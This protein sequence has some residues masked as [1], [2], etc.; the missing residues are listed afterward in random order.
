MERQIEARHEAP[1][2]VT[3][4][5]VKYGYL[6]FIGEFE[7]HGRE[8]LLPSHP[9]LVETD[10]GIELGQ[11]LCYSCDLERGLCVLPERIKEYLGASGPEYLKRRAGK[12]VRPANAQDLMEEQH[13]RA[14]AMAKKSFCMQAAQRYSLKLKIICVE[15]LFG[16]E[17]I[18]FY[19]TA[20]GRVD[21]RELVRELAREY[22]TR[23]ELRQIGARDEARLLADYE[24]CGRECCCKNFLKT[25]RPVNMKMAKLQKATLDPSKV[26]GRCGRLRCCLRYE[27]RTYEDLV[28]QL[29]GI[30]SFVQTPN[31]IG[32][33]KDR[34]VLTQL[35]QVVLEDN[36]LV[37]FP[38]EELSP[39]PPRDGREARD[40][41]D[42]RDSRDR[43]PAPNP[44]LTDSALNDEDEADGP[45]D[46]SLEEAA[47]P[48]AAGDEGPR[49]PGADRSGRPGGERPAGAGGPPGGPDGGSRRNRRNR[50]RKRRR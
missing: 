2:S 20:E 10:R 33:V 34:I 18:I 30:G 39:A 28:S 13:I 29:P 14:D 12:V 11:F 45:A 6:G 46:R 36:R 24:I 8:P 4:A 42:N 17:R 32:R 48:P 16:G 19:F 23:I 37:T 47:A 35:V 7:Y 21:F 26:S 25:L 41:R 44:E 9:V 22:Q 1:A 50:G 43:V 40:S 31:G 5:V 38:V 3:T 49:R 15:H 27:Q